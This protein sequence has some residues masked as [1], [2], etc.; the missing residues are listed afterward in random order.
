MKNSPILVSSTQKKQTF[1]GIH[2][3][4]RGFNDAVGYWEAVDGNGKRL[5]RINCDGVATDGLLVSSLETSVNAE[6]C[7]NSVTLA[8]CRIRGNGANVVSFRDQRFFRAMQWASE[9]YQK[10]AINQRPLAAGERRS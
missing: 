6:V 3:E 9:Q 10:A 4:W 8:H 7:S 1:A 5:R 2:W